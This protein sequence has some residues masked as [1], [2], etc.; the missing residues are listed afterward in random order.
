MAQIYLSYYLL[1]IKREYGSIAHKYLLGI[2]CVHANLIR[3]I[4]MGY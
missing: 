4:F 1:L 2:E 3:S